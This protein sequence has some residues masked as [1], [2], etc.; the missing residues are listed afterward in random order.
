M[1]ILGKIAI[2]KMKK[3]YWPYKQTGKN[4]KNNQCA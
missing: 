2:A 3:F 4:L 1:E